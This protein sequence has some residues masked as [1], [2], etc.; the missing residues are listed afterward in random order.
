MRS[1]WPLIWLVLAAVCGFALFHTSQR[2]NDDRQRLAELSDLTAREEESLR[3]LGAEWSYLNQPARLEKLA[4]E[5]LSM[6]PMKGKQFTTKENLAAL[7]PP[8]E[9]EPAAGNPAAVPVPA[10]A[11]AL[12]PVAAPVPVPVK[13]RPAPTMPDADTPNFG[14]L[15]R[16]IGKE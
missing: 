6:V 9:A 5:R 15:M 13:A 16:R 1:R 12:V 4:R 2:V 8:Q 3:V 11:P 7:Q 10:P 14:D